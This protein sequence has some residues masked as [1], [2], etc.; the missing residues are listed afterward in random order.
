MS[1]FIVPIGSLPSISSLS[2]LQAANAARNTGGTGMPFADFLQNAIEDMSVT[3]QESQA[4]MQDLALGGSDDLHTGALAALK[5][6][7]AMS[8][9]AGLVSAVITSYKEIMQTQL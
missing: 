5:S 9:T 1:Q 4:S 3:N 8:Y 2:D 6:T 7:T